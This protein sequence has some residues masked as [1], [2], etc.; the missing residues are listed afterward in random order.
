M[1]KDFFT[2]RRL[3]YSLYI[4]L[5]MMLLRTSFLISAVAFLVSIAHGNAFTTAPSV[6]VRPASQQVA[7][8]GL[9]DEVGNFMKRFTQKATASHILIKGGAEAA[10]KLEDLKAKIGNN[11]VKF[12]EFASQFS[13]CPSGRKGGNLGEF[14]PGQMV[15]EFDQV[16]FSEPVGVVHGPIKT[17][18]RPLYDNALFGCESLLI[19]RSRTIYLFSLAIT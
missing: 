2:F 11:P 3:P 7:M 1:N 4:N 9:M 16:V 17:Q 6:G 10:N 14:G 12:A 8:G 5:T 19:S 13:S 15:R 18:V